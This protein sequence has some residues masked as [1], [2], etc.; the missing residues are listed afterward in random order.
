MAKKKASSKAETPTRT[1]AA[2]RAKPA[3]PS[4]KAENK[5][6]PAP[7]SGK[8]RTTRNGREARVRMYRHGLGDCFLV[9]FPRGDGTPFT[10]L[11]DCGLILGTPNAEALMKPVVDDILATTRDPKTGKSHLQV[12]VITHEHWDH[13][14][15]FVQFQEQFDKVEID[16]VWLAWTEDPHDAIAQRLRQE[17]QQ[18][19]AA[20]WLGFNGLKQRLAAT[21][22]RAEKD[23]A[24]QEADRAAQ[25][26]SFFGIDP[27]K[28]A[29][30]AGL[31]FGT[32]PAF[33]LSKTG[34]AMQWARQKTAR[35]RFCRPGDVIELEGTG[36]IRAYVLGPPTDLAQLH[37]DR[38]SRDGQE[39]YGLAE[40]MPAESERSFF[41]AAL[42]TPEDGRVAPNADRVLPFDAK[43]RID[44]KQAKNFDFFREHYFGSGE[45]DVEA[46]RR[47][48]GE[49][50]A[51]SA[52]LALKLDSDTNNTSL[53]LA[54]ELPDRRV[55]L[56]P[57][58]AQVGNWESWHADSRG[59]KRVWEVGARSVQ[60]DGRVI[61]ED[62]RHVTAEELLNRTVFYKVSHHGSHNATLR[63]KG[64]EMMIDANLVALVPVD[65]YVA[66]EMKH[67]KQM[68]FVPL[69]SRL[70]D[71]TRDRVVLADQ[72]ARPFPAGPVRVED[73]AQKIAVLDAEGNPAKR[74]LYVD[75]IFTLPDSHVNK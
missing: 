75:L 11:I 4:G 72:P 15:G 12:L 44:P 45:D 21:G 62:A 19:L 1:K 65:T 66:H 43:F 14:S 22:R 36:G 9:T 18:R 8:A 54:F 61:T 25:V 67:W 53:V 10:I 5:A 57:A 74:P 40:T 73:A 42:S 33:G 71:L 64:L 17:R 24:Q 29:P 49:W 26:L 16:Q 63:Q 38:H 55:F 23:P 3:T 6:R 47:I 58:D 20:L 41:A 52:E 35:P 51:Q 70:A 48:E 7:R 46:C 69:L 37:K 32:V 27:V 60:I 50:V 39:T 28:D 34:D 59:N 30:P 13:L 56:F 31:T 2:G 68:P